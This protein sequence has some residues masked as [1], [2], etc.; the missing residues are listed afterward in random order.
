MKTNLF[1]LA[2]ILIMVIPFQSHARV[3]FGIDENEKELIEWTFTKAQKLSGISSL[4]PENRWK[5]SQIY[6]LS[7][8]E[9]SAQICPE[10]PINCHGLV[11]LYDTKTKN[12]YLR[13]DLNPINDMISVSFLL[14]EMVHSLQHEHKTED[15]MFG[16]CEKLYATEKE[17]YTAQD[18]FLKSEGQFFRAG[19][20][21]RFFLCGDK[22]RD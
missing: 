3:Q 10:D 9:L 5:K 15:E 2:G 1:L 4:D 21:L 8:E 13:E 22:L 20:A 14:H 7:D 16:T 11:G 6:L 17:A 18:A 12:I 19:N